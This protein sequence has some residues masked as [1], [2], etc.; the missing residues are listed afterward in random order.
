[1]PS[2]T[3][4]TVTPAGLYLPY[5]M[6]VASGGYNTS[7]TGNGAITGA[8]VLNNCV[9]YSQ[10]RML[11]MYNEMYGST[12][13]NP[14]SMFNANAEDWYQIAINNGF[15]VG[16]VPQLGAVGVYYSALQNVGHV[17]NVEAYNNGV[18]EISEGHY[19][20]PNNLGSWD[21]SYL[22]ANY[23]PAFMGGDTSFTVYGFIYPFRDTPTPTPTR[24]KKMP[25][26]MMLRNPTLFN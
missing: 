13:S 7:I 12:T 11:E 16:T 6:T 14:F 3:P 20:Y 21:Y 5:Y 15:S 24:R 25:V 8:N 26:W 23:R 17:V 18:W 9:G 1:M 2:F 4:R 10:G 19:Y 22:D